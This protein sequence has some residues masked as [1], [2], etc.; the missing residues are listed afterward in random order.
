[1]EMH[2]SVSAMLLLLFVKLIH[3]ADADAADDDGGDGN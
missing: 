3:D 1:M 2:F